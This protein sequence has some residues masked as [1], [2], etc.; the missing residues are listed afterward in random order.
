MLLCNSE[1]KT[2]A[3]TEAPR[4]H[5]SSLNPDFTPRAA[6]AQAWGPLVGNPTGSYCLEM[7]D[8]KHLVAARR[9]AMIN[10][11]EKSHGITG[12]AGRHDTSQVWFYFHE[13]LVWLYRLQNQP[14]SAQRTSHLSTFRRGLARMGF[15]RS[16]CL[17][18]YSL[19]Q[20]I[21]S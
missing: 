10:H 16:D 12:A 9:L 13:A 2:V 18:A 7:C 21:Y 3:P 17:C 14:G 8:S 1:S 4:S 6:A 20:G 11:A 19:M 15:A 5:S